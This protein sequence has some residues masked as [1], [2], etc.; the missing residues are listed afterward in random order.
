MTSSTVVSMTI[1]L[2]DPGIIGT[3]DVTVTVEV[4]TY[5]YCAICWTMVDGIE[6]VSVDGLTITTDG[7]CVD[8]DV[9]D[10]GSVV[11]T[12]VVDVL[13]VFVVVFLGV[14]TTVELLR[15]GTGITGM[16][17]ITGVVEYGEVV[18]VVGYVEIIGVGVTSCGFIVVVSMLLVV[19][20]GVVDVDVEVE[21][22]EVVDVD[23]VG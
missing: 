20:D 1:L 13:V 14:K 22:D 11:G 23:V 19:V 6:T 2:F 21:L 4:G 9:A 17:G 7:C 3:G 16:T 10:S 8:V 5:D 12:F 15:L 18:F